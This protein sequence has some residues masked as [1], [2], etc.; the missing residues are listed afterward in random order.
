MGCFIFNFNTNVTPR[1]FLVGITFQLINYCV[2][3][4]HEEY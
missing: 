1:W 3:P 2:P 4:P